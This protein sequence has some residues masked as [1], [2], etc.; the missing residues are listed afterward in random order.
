MA[1]CRNQRRIKYYPW[2]NE[3]VPG[4]TLV[5][6]LNRFK[7]SLDGAVIIM[8]PESSTT[9][10]GTRR[11]IPNL[12]VLFEFGYFFGIFKHDHVA[13]VKYGGVYLPSD[14]D[15]YIP[16]YGGAVYS[17]SGVAPPPGGRTK[18]EF[19]RWVGKL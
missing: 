17:A 3:F 13:I 11:R 5:N 18:T 6:E 12:N 9:L 4:R 1:K 7:G 19:L 15:G 16:I 8:T 10:R 14:L 2:W